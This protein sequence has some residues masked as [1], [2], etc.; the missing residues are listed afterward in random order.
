MLPVGALLAAG[1]WFGAWW[2]LTGRLKFQRLV[3]QARFYDRRGFDGPQLVRSLPICCVFVG[4]LGSLFVVS[5]VVQLPVFPKSL[6]AW[7]LGGGLVLIAIGLMPVYFT[8][9]RW[10][11]PRRLLIPQIRDMSDAELRRLFP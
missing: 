7:V 1:G 8:V 2:T 6:A 3:G 10:G 9:V 11:R 4:A 5:T